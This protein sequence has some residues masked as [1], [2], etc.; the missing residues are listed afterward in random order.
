[1]KVLPIEKLI[2]INKISE[3]CNETNEPIFITKNGQ[4]DMVIMNINAYKEK[5]ERIEMHEAILEG[6]SS[7]EEGKVVNGPEVLNELKRNWIE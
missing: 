1:M 2:D 6:L 5:F 4:T 7:V 3:L